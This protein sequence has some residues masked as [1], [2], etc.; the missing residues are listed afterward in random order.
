MDAV[1]WVALESTDFR[2]KSTK[3][4]PKA[5]IIQGFYGS[6]TGGREFESRY[7]DQKYG[8]SIALPIFLFVVSRLDKFRAA[9]CECANF[10]GECVKLACKPSAKLFFRRQSPRHILFLARIDSNSYCEQSE[11]GSSALILRRA[12][13]ARI[14][15][16]S[17][18]IL[19]LGK[20]P[21]ALNINLQVRN[22][23]RF[24]LFFEHLNVF[25][26][27]LQLQVAFFKNIS[28]KS[29]DFYHII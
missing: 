26:N 19:P 22:R 25:F 20:A 7:F 10:A 23:H 15:A 1:C 11:A 17:R 13:D 2:Y 6:G 9:E 28:L 12:H 29:I 27:I 3:N 18:I 5:L 8:E 16:A 24:S 21:A 14:N 4:H